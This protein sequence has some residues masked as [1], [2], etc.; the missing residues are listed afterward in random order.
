MPARRRLT[1]RCARDVRKKTRVPGEQWEAKRHERTTGELMGMTYWCEK[2]KREFSGMIHF[3]TIVIIYIYICNNHP[4]KPQQPIHS[5]R[6][7]PVMVV[8]LSPRAR[9][10]A[11][12]RRCKEAA[13]EVADVGIENLGRMD[14]ASGCLTVCYGKLRKIAHFYG[15]II[16]KRLQEI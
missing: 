9:F 14:F 8:E 4:S 6:L 5:R 13:R 1:L 3:I 12:K 16:R 15:Y 11:S 10:R 2:T 7:A